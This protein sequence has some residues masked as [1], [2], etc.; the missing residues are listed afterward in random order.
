[1]CEP[2]VTRLRKK[3]N[4]VSDTGVPELLEEAAQE[5]ERLRVTADEWEQIARVAGVVPSKSADWSDD[6]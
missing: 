6:T 4:F 5:I 3:R 1:M 2:L